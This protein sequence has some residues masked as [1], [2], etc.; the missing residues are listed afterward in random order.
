MAARERERLSRVKNETQS[1]P[2]ATAPLFGVPVRVQEASDHLSHSV[3]QTLGPFQIVSTSQLSTL[4]GIPKQPQTPVEPF[5]AQDIFK[6]NP[7]LIA[8]LQAQHNG[9]HPV[10]SKRKS[11]HSNKG[12]T[13]SKS[14]SSGDPSKPG[15]SQEKRKPSKQ[16][17]S[18]SGSK[19][20]KGSSQRIRPPPSDM[21][22]P[23]NHTDSKK[24][25]NKLN[26]LENCAKAADLSQP[27]PTLSPFTSDNK[28]PAKPQ[29]N[30]GLKVDLN[31][32][33]HHHPH[34]QQNTTNGPSFGMDVDMVDGVTEE[35][36]AN[37]TRLAQHQGHI[38]RPLSRTEPSKDKKV[39]DILR[40]YTE[41]CDFQ[42]LSAN[43]NTP[44]EET[45][46]RFPFNLNDQ[47][48]EIPPTIEELEEDGEEDE[49]EEEEEEDEK[50]ETRRFDDLQNSD[51]SEKEEDNSHN[52]QT[53][54]SEEET[55]QVT[56]SAMVK[57]DGSGES[58]SSEDEETPSSSDSEESESEESSIQG[59]QTRDPSPKPMG[60]SFSLISQF[61]KVQKE[62][63]FTPRSGPFSENVDSSSNNKSSSAT[64]LPKFDGLNNNAKRNSPSPDPES[65]TAPQN[66]E[67]RTENHDADDEE[68]EMEQ[69][70]SSKESKRG[71]S[72]STP[73]KGG[74]T[75]SKK[76]GRSSEL[77][78]TPV[79]PSSKCGGG[80]PGVKVASQGKV[81]PAARSTKPFGAGKKV[82][83]KTKS[84]AE[85]NDG[86]EVVVASS[87]K[88]TSVAS[89]KSSSAKPSNSKAKPKRKVSRAK[90]E[91]KFPSKPFITSS[92]SEE[93][94]RTHSNTVHPTQEHV[95]HKTEKPTE[96]RTSRGK[97]PQ[98]HGVRKEPKGPPHLSKIRAKSAPERR[99]VPQ[100]N[101][102]SSEDETQ[103]V[104]SPVSI[105][106]EEKVDI[107]PPPRETGLSLPKGDIPHL[108][109]SFDLALIRHL[110]IKEEKKS[111]SLMFGPPKRKDPLDTEKPSAIVKPYHTVRGRESSSDSRKEKNSRS[112]PRRSRTDS[113]SRSPRRI[114][115]PPL[116]VAEQPP[117][118]DR[119]PILPSDPSRTLDRRRSASQHEDLSSMEGPHRRGV[120]LGEHEPPPPKRPRTDRLD[121]RENGRQQVENWNCT[122]PN[123]EESPEGI[124]TGDD[125]PIHRGGSW[126]SEGFHRQ[127]YCRRHS[128]EERQQFTSDGYLAE[129]KRLKHL[130]DSQ[131]DKYKQSLTYFEAALQFIMC[132][133]NFERD[134]GYTDE[135]AIRMYSDTCKIINYVFRWLI[136]IHS[137]SEGRSNDKKLAVLC[138][139][140]QALLNMRMYKLKRSATTKLSKVLNDHFKSSKSSQQNQSSW[141]PSSKYSETPSPMS[142]TPSPAGSVGS[143][144]SMGSQG[145]NSSDIPSATTS[146]KMGPGMNMSSGG[147]MVPSRIYHMMST[148]MTNS[149]YCLTSID[150]WEQAEALS[151]ENQDF[152][153]TVQE[154]CGVLTLH[155]SILDLVQYSEYCLC[156][157]KAL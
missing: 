25:R 129:G 69:A 68:D 46:P 47:V 61:R 30:S 104:L 6:M 83:E 73:L 11:N 62:Q 136:G 124:F 114:R 121:S 13:G 70:G 127:S 94:V 63:K 18:K 15:N 21:P 89:G 19:G 98:V 128:F 97:S 40:I 71:G 106:Q 54:G 39:Q 119:P 134:P 143:V 48:S 31:H 28:L 85:K 154:Q 152:F 90:K 93:D 139:R 109:V 141:N 148:Y 82:R 88:R 29:N 142:P 43:I 59:G 135:K 26:K 51:E 99:R 144:G 34:Q 131:T 53:K 146:S 1:Q 74:K 36:L 65:H 95:E 133:N 66:E 113:S 92:D 84:K 12:S 156:K 50:E 10:S 33:N 44:I 145:S 60:K 17:S 103:T 76:S 122:E 72:S 147:T 2:Q 67:D 91:E 123:H 27:M 132:G 110:P 155:S 111:D 157:L 56:A 64:L 22:K 20:S 118:I 9:S 52:N 149:T 96:H 117:D 150:Y 102:D 80:S 42:P 86:E 75:G 101:M 41:Q 57:E 138:Y 55:T 78:K 49:E 14:G 77:K 16:L 137:G 126:E 37:A 87:S 100:K 32:H 107:V 4:I 116:L 120:D 38:M 35:E 81:P 112:E 7:A 153:Q 58:S 105:K 45:A 5:P 23:D 115:E 79:K 3:Q 125:G 130:A 24:A 108:V 8:D 151:Q 140:F